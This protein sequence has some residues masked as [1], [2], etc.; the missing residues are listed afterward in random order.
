MSDTSTLQPKI[1]RGDKV[2]I[3]GSAG[4]YTVLRKEVF[5]RGRA[6]FYYTSKHRRHGY[7]RDQLTKVD[8]KKT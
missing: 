3:K 6:V 4:V 2:R 8:G 5:D 1:N 7:R